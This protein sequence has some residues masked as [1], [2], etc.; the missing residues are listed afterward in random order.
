MLA[1][2]DGALTRSSASSSSSSSSRRR[3]S[4]C[5]GRSCARA[6]CRRRAPPS[7]TSATATAIT[8]TA[9]APS[10]TRNKAR[11]ARL[12]RPRRRRRHQ[13]PRH[14]RRHSLVS[15]SRGVSRGVSDR[16]QSASM[17]NES[18]APLPRHASIRPSEAFSLGAALTSGACLPA[19]CGVSDSKCAAANLVGAEQRHQADQERALDAE[20]R[21]GDDTRGW[22]VGL[23]AV[24][25]LVV[26]RERVMRELLETKR[27]F[28]N[29]LH[30]TWCV[31]A[32]SCWLELEARASSHC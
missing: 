10:S 13:P 2:M 28:V 7:L 14:S 1:K 30:N 18:V 32:C 24:S 20:G 4:P 6:P 19:V 21:V 31:R 8:T 23:G 3:R 15:P 11:G 27:L 5:G 16:A 12:S 22:T 9:R 17:L 25:R 26:H 29:G